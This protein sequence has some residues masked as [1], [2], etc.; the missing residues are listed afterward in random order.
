MRHTLWLVLLFAA[1]AHATLIQFDIHTPLSAVNVDRWAMDVPPGDIDVSFIVD[2]SNAL[3]ESSVIQGD[4][5]GLCFT[6][7]R[8]ALRGSLLNAS[9]GG[10]TIASGLL[11]GTG[12]YSGD[13][14]SPCHDGAIQGFF[15]GFG[16]SFANSEFGVA[17]NW[18]T[19]HEIT[20]AEVFASA[21]PVAAF[22]LSGRY[23]GFM[24]LT[25]GDQLGMTSFS[26]VFAHE[27]PEPSTLGLFLLS[28][29]VGLTFRPQR[30]RAT[31]PRNN[32]PR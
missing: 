5:G 29:V 24:F 16:L 28:A 15:A 21:D 4:Q 14:P 9:V 25:N 26:N 31:T 19:I 30:R 8:I 18:D 20:V 17:L 6:H 27:V 7:V 11:G 32:L 22:L 13:S 12:T 23:L 3:F 2:T 1:Q 10:Q